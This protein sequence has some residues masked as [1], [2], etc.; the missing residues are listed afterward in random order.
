[1]S[2]LKVATWN[3]NSLKVRLPHILKW[4]EEEK[5]DVLALQEIKME[6]KNFP[7]DIFKEIGYPYSIANGQKTYNGVA[8]ISRLPLDEIEMPDLDEQHRIISATVN[9][10]RI[11][12]IYVPNGEAVDSPKYQY[13]LNW[14]LK[15]KKYLSQ[16]L[17]IYSKVIVLGDFNIAPSD[18][19]V[20]DPKIWEGQV[21]FSSLEKNALTEIMNLGFIDS[22]RLFPQ[23]EKSF[24]WWDYRM[25]AFRRNAGLRIDHI[26]ISEKLKLFC[27]TCVVQKEPRRWERPSDHVPVLLTLC[28]MV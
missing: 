19:D 23:P 7:E 17:K 8:I 11:I 4:L 24:T 25:L 6:T 18:E 21:L 5:P 1:M 26:L 13:K 15:F 16:Q 10:I 27:K 3:V 12:N 28:S 20:H 2:E 14:L 9:Q 22:F